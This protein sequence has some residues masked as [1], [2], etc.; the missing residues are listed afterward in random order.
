MVRHC[1]LRNPLLAVQARLD[2]PTAGSE[3]LSDLAAL[4][5]RYVEISELLLCYARALGGRPA[6]S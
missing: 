6:R 4:A 2:D 1:C 5:F 3:D